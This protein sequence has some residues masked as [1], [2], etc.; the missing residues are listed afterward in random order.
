MVELEARREEPEELVQL[1]LN[2]QQQLQP[3]AA[4]ARVWTTQLVFPMLETGSDRTAQQQPQGQQ[5]QFET[6]EKGWL[7]D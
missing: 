1:S 6:R 4:P 7:A 3:P 5:Q 2:Q